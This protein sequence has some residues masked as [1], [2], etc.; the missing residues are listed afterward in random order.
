M[1]SVQQKSLENL[2]TAATLCSFLEKI[3]ECIHSECIYKT[4]VLCQAP[5]WHLMSLR[6]C[7]LIEREITG[8]ALWHWTLTCCLQQ[9][10]FYVGGCSCFACPIPN[11]APR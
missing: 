7:I 6:S 2:V 9:Q 8:Q 10:L 5:E 11:Q 4:P 3:W 1:A